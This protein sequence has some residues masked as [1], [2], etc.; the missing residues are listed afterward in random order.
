MDSLCL[1]F[2]DCVCHGL[3]VSFMDSM[4]LLVYAFLRHFWQN[5][6]KI[7]IILNTIC[8]WDLSLSTSS[9]SA[10]SDFL[11]PWSKPIHDW[12]PASWTRA[13]ME[14]FWTGTGSGTGF[15]VSSWIRLKPGPDPVLKLDIRIYIRILSR[16]HW[17][18]QTGPSY[19]APVQDPDPVRF[20]LYWLHFGL[21]TMFGQ[22]I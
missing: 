5:L 15:A 2:A 11:V 13:W 4:C 22:Q 20:R 9:A 6:D 21:T 16:I 14:V 12:I 3:S 10:A 19:M 8:P 1:S 18:W 7:L 17:I